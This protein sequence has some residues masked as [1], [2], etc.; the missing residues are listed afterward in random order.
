MFANGH[1]SRSLTLRT[2]APAFPYHFIITTTQDHTPTPTAALLAF[3]YLV[4]PDSPVLF[5]MAS[6]CK[7]PNPQL[8]PR[9]TSVVVLLSPIR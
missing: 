5:P 3:T 9:G 7:I 1:I 6:D 4:I 8:N 2:Y